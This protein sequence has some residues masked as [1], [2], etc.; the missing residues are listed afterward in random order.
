[1][2][3]L[4]PKIENILF[5]GLGIKRALPFFGKNEN[6]QNNSKFRMRVCLSVLN[7]VLYFFPVLSALFPTNYACKN[8][9]LTKETFCSAKQ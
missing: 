4:E 6:R 5:E 8:W 7:S 9:T 2:Y 3:N 1:M